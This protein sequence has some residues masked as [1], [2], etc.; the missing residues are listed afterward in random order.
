M[1]YKKINIKEV[2]SI[3]DVKKFLNET[4]FN[5]YQSIELPY[6]LKTPGMDRSKSADFV[7]KYPI[8][9]KSV[10]DVGC[11]YGYFCNEALR[12]G[13]KRVTGI[14]ISNENVKIARKIVELWNRNIEIQLK[15][16]LDFNSSEKYD[17]VLFLNV[18]HHIVSPTL[19][20]KEISEIAKELAIVEFSTIFDRH[21][22][23]SKIQKFFLNFL[24]KKTPFAFVGSR[25][26]H[27]IW[28]F[29]KA[30]F[31][32]LVVNQLEL[33]RKVEFIKSPR[34]KGRLIAFCWK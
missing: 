24:F 28:Y 10:L 14:E 33:F 29:S 17:I 6:G 1:E 25:R 4:E 18:L 32:N 23:F 27:R 21:T 19:A 16:F 15:D 5:G 30:S 12:R 9:N 7:F 20:L 2:A 34:K 31:I 11:K 13:A 26:Y 3:E 8:K 22:G